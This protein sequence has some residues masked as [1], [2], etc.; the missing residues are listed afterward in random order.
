MH[1]LMASIR[2]VT[3]TTKEHKKSLVYLLDGLL[4]DV[5]I[6]NSSR[7]LQGR[8]TDPGGIF[9]LALP[10]AGIA[11][12]EIIK[13]ICATPKSRY[14]VIFFS[15][16][17]LEICPILNAS[18]DYCSWGCDKT[19][20]VFRLNQIVLTHTQL[21]HSAAMNTEGN[22]WARLNFIGESTVFQEVLAM[23]KVAA[24]CAAP[25]LIEG[26]TG[27]GKEMAARA[28]HN[29]SGR[30][31]YPFIPV[32]CGAVPDHLFENELFGHEKGA[33]TDAKQNHA[34]LIEQADGGT[35]FLD[36]IEALSA[37]GQVTLLRFLEDKIIKPLGSQKSKTVDVR[38]IVA[39]NSPVAELV[40]QGLFRSDL[41][42]RLNLLHV[43]LPSLCEREGDIEY[44]AEFFMQKYREQ[45][46][47]ANKRIHPQTMDWMRTYQWPGNVRELEN[48]IH[49]SF[50]LSEDV[51]IRVNSENVADKQS[52]SR[53]KLFD[54]RM[55]FD[56]DSS[57][58]VAK[59][60]MIK[61][62]EKK[63]LSCLI[64]K[65]NGNVTLAAS[66]AQKERRAL[67]KLLKKHNIDP[68]TFRSN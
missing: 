41:L 12:N 34:G 52:N 2:L 45:Y 38:I 14:L 54:R 29:L 59:Q 19:E 66:E 36:E 22:V 13:A 32:N 61:L 21:D 20:L 43:P 49:R 68:A 1:K 10:E 58:N 8:V 64:A 17:T 9:V 30:K 3:L 42:Y 47:Q 48:F 25:V 23:I 6:I 51:Y 39:S 44:I 50:L 62:F 27:C 46:Q 28:I 11:V 33:Y 60:N 53:R 55:S 24:R 56:F 31:E 57:F 16:I 7:W 26:E 40:N 37:K 65:S 67:G 18:D 63:Y 15:P 35:L 4:D 5:S